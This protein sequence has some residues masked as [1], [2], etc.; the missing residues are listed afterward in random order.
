[1]V[2]EGHMSIMSTLLVHI[3]VYV[4]GESAMEHL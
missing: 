4:C 3:H 1:M 2:S